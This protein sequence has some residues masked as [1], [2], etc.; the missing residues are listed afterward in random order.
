MQRHAM[1]RLESWLAA[2]ARKPLL[3]RGARQVGKSTLVRLFAER[4]KRQVHEVDLERHPELDAIFASRDTSRILSE[5]EF[6]IDKGPIDDHA[7]LLFLDEIQAA[8]S[9]VAALRSL[10]EDRPDLPIIAAGSLLEF[11]LADHAFSMP[12]GRIEYLFLEAMSFEEFLAALDETSLLELL[13]TYDLDKPFPGTAHTRLLGRLRDYMLVGGMPEAVR[14]FAEAG[15]FADAGSVH[16][17]ILETYRDD[18]AKYGTRSEIAQLRRVYG[19]VPGAVGEKFKYSRVDSDARSRDIKRALELLVMAR[20]VRRVT[21][22]D[23]TG[24]PLGATLKESAFKAYFLDVGLVNA[25]CGIDRL[26]PEQVADARFV[27]EGPMA[28]QFIAQHLP[29]LAPD[30]RAF[31]PTYWLRE[32]RANNA[33]VDFVQQFGPD[34][35]PIE[36]KAGKSG[37]LKSLLEMVAARRFERA[38]R[39]DTN[40]PLVQHVS[41]ARTHG[42][43]DIE[44]TLLSLPLYMV[45]QTGRLWRN[46]A[47]GDTP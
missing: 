45:E 22:T 9:A 42:D 6:L 32:G 30:D 31:T 43:N 39:F 37:S 3:I 36:V 25:A 12:V 13:R 14:V 15:S 35:A 33:E 16:A 47:G 27:N 17:S 10:H 34:I 19:F 18:F 23:A 11:I 4:S 7:S 20:V 44:F 46:L 41:H 24:L 26:T 2:S 38:L 8:P 21:H 29:L 40:P 5:L 1:K 28:E